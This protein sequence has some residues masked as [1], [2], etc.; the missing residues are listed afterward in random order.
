MTSDKLIESDPEA[1]RLLSHLHITLLMVTPE[2]GA[3][4]LA[5]AD[6]V[7]QRDR[8]RVNRSLSVR[9][10]KFLAYAMLED[11][12]KPVGDPIRLAYDPEFGPYCI[13]GQTRLTGLVDAEATLPMVV[14]CDFPNDL[15]P[16]LDGRGPRRPA[17]ALF[18]DGENNTVRLAAMA[19]WVIQFENR[20]LDST[21]FRD[22][23]AIKNTVARHSRLPHW[24][25]VTANAQVARLGVVGA[26]LYWIERSRDPRA[27][28]FCETL[29]SGE[30]LLSGSPVLALRERLLQ[31]RK[32]DGSRSIVATLCFS[33]W[34]SFLKNQS[35]GHL[36]ASA[37]VKWPAHC[38][39]IAQ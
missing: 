18:V 33:A 14:Y 34:D 21:E 19:G 12:F 6:L 20:H 31:K 16:Y 8:A 30:G 35:V 1:V 23:Y 13:D 9:R 3:N 28:E 37:A 4:W 15:F 7:A 24:A 10:V 11:E 22:G 2:R 27:R 17:D 5:A 36:V 39:Y 25:Q 32:E 26:A 38:P 29:L